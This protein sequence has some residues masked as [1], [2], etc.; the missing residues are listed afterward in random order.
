MEME[1][2]NYSELIQNILESHSINH[3]EDDT[4]IQ[5][6]FDTKRDRYLIMGQWGWVFV[7]SL[8]LI[9]LLIGV[10]SSIFP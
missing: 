7:A 6:I 5:I 3:V 2:V 10:I 9:P 8:V 4:E 1:R